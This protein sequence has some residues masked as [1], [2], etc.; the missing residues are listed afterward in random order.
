MTKRR[1]KPGRPRTGHDPVVTVRLA[2]AILSIFLI[3][4][5]ELGTTRSMVVRLAMEDFAEYGS[6]KVRDF[7]PM[8]VAAL[9]DG[10][11]YRRHG[12]TGKIA[13]TARTASSCRRRHL[14]STPRRV[15]SAPR[16]VNAITST[17]SAWA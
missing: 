11:R 10:G 2:A 14:A 16:N 4:A 12:V 6:R 5:A 7:R 17:R 1:R 13:A 8:F 9:K 15:R 3:T